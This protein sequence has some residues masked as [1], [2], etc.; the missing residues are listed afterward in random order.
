MNNLP[1]TSNQNIW[2][3]KND[4]N[5][6]ITKKLVYLKWSNSSIVVSCPEWNE[7]FILIYLTITN[8]LL[9][10][11]AYIQLSS[12][13]IERHKL[14]ILP[15]APYSFLQGVTAS[16]Y[17]PIVRRT[18]RRL[19][20]TRRRTAPPNFAFDADVVIIVLA[21]AEERSFLPRR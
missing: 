17:S 4:L 20:A 15:R 3:I 5:Y 9:D 16:Q 1:N 2:H 6:T 11:L 8:L 12:F 10:F 7:K 19:S 18:I 21:S 13:R 14:W